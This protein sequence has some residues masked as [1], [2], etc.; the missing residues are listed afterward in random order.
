M[1]TERSDHMIHCPLCCTTCLKDVRFWDEPDESTA[2]LNHV[3]GT[4][5]I[6]LLSSY[7]Y[8]SKLGSSAFR[9][10]P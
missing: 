2:Q 9:I 1:A 6:H 4:L 10:W 5:D 8:V 7:G 3:S